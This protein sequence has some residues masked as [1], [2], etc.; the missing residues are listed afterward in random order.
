MRI[1]ATIGAIYPT[2]QPKQNEMT[3]NVWYG[4][5][6]GY[7]AKD[8]EKKAL[9]HIKTSPYPPSISELIPQAEPVDANA[10][11]N[12][13]IRIV[14]HYGY[15]RQREALEEMTDAQ[16]EAVRAIG[17]DRICQSAPESLRR[18]FITVYKPIET[19]VTIV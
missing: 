12:E 8:V 19:A 9:Q 16:R 18:E 2:F 7:S 3:A 4:I 5:M 6:Q 10:E 14:A 15:Y 13:V 1:I 11:Y 17:Y